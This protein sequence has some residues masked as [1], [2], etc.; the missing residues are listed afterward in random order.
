MRAQ[1][2]SISEPVVIEWK[3]K[4][5]LDKLRLLELLKLHRVET[6][7]VENSSVMVADVI[8]ALKKAKARLPETFFRDLASELELPF[9][10]DSDVREIYEKNDKLDV[11]SS[12]PY[13]LIRKHGFILV[14]IRGDSSIESIDVAVDNPLD[15]SGH[16]PHRSCLR[17]MDN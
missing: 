10:P 5:T 15:Q 11:I 4:P 7:L 8:P 1:T 13:T 3:P 14:G 12:A 6:E 16:S 2:G 9:V 17:R